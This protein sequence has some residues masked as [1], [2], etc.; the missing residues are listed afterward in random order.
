MVGGV[1]GGDGVVVL[2]S[3]V[4][5]V[6]CLVMQYQKPSDTVSPHGNNAFTLSAKGMDWWW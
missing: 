5:G 2:V 1:G 6:I 4:V 3:V